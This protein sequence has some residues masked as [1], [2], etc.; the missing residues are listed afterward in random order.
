M[1]TAIF[2]ISA[3][4]KRKVKTGFAD[5][6]DAEAYVR[7]HYGQKL[8]CFERDADNPGTADFF[9]ASGS[10]YAIEPEKAA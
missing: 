6:D 3:M 2:E 7:A 1:P 5:L 4:S 9:V 10:V 8:V